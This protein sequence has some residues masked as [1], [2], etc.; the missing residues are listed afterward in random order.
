MHLTSNSENFSFDIQGTFNVFN[1]FLVFGGWQD[2]FL[3][4][5]TFSNDAIIGYHKI[6]SSIDIDI[7]DIKA[8]IKDAQEHISTISINFNTTIWGGIHVLGTNINVV[9]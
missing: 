8:S 9:D 3:F 5:V 6:F 4:I 2:Q 7:T 1:T